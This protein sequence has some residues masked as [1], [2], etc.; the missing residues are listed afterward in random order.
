MSLDLFGCHSGVCMCMCVCVCMCCAI[1]ACGAAKYRT[2]P[3]NKEFLSLK[4]QE[5]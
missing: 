5:C 3:D 2:A 1:E 4:C